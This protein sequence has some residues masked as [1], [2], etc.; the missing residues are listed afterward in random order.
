MAE[1][2]QDELN[3]FL[4]SLRPTLAAAININALKDGIKKIKEIN[5][6]GN[7]EISHKEVINYLAPKVA[8]HFNT[9]SR[10]ILENIDNRIKRDQAGEDCNTL[11]MYSHLDTAPESVIKKEN[12]LA[13]LSNDALSNPTLANLIA[14]IVKT[15]DKKRELTYKFANYALQDTIENFS[16]PPEHQQKTADLIEPKVMEISKAAVQDIERLLEANPKIKRALQQLPNTSRLSVNADYTCQA[17]FPEAGANNTKQQ[18][19]QDAKQ[20]MSKR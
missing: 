7:K 19:T 8:A 17:L 1:P 2:T 11:A 14:G 6:D 15:P 5:A 10:N 18:A 20:T 16:I 4:N 13:S 9:S 12:A 3:D